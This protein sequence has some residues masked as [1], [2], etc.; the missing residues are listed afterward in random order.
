[1]DGV[2]GVIP[3]LVGIAGTDGVALVTVAP[4]PRGA[5]VAVAAIARIGLAI[6]PSRAHVESD[7]TDH[8]NHHKQCK[9][10]LHLD[11]L[12]EGLIPTSSFSCAALPFS[13][14]PRS[15]FSITFSIRQYE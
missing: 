12:V 5:V 9:S 15:R 8:A 6:R 3:D 11:L 4:L 13:A 10:P 2:T 14:S 7:Q 1:M